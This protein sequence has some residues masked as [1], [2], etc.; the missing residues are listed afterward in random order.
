MQVRELLLSAGERIRSALGLETSPVAFVGDGVRF[1]NVA[2]VFLLGS[3][4][5]LEVAPKFLG[6]TEGWREDFFL[7]A[8]LDH[9]GRLLDDEGVRASASPSSNL[10]T[11]IGRSF[12]GMYWRNHRRPLRTYKRRRLTDFTLDGDF[13]PVDLLWPSEEG[14]EQGETAFT[15]ANP[16]NAV[17]A[18]AASRL[19]PL[20]SDPETRARLERVAQHLPRQ[21]TPPRVE[22]RML[23]SRAKAWQSTYDLAVDVLGGLGGSY[24]PRTAMAPG[25]I[26]KTWHAWEYLVT[27]GLR[28]SFG[29]ARVSRQSS[30]PLGVRRRRGGNWEAV[31]VRPDN[32]VHLSSGPVVVDAKYKG[33]VAYGATEV[34]SADLYEGLA[35]AKAAGTREVVLAYP[36]RAAEAGVLPEDQAGRFREFCEITV[37]GVTV[38]GV[39]FGVRG[40]SKPHGLRTFGRAFSDYFAGLV[41]A[42]VPGAA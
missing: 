20:V 36:R 8:T 27:L 32:I 38:R 3:G 9:H 17:I 18:G 10:F 29:T 22:D 28:S 37:D 24:D 34:S 19:A 23:P 31:E 35:F 14:F 33:N 11:L 7:L 42:A 2:G 15:R 1:E 40:I 39:E 12:V 4:I 25:Y 26:L 21:P 41:S 6:H 5:E 13:D 30:Q 16:F